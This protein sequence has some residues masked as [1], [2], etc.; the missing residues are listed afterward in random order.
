MKNFIDKINAARI[1][2]DE[3]YKKSQNF[4]IINSIKYQLD[5][6]ADDFDCS[7]NFKFTAAKE[8]VERLILGVQAVREI[9]PIYPEFADLLCEIDYEYKCLYGI[10]CF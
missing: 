2:A 6:I 10:D 5:F 9:E 4:P 3:I 1:I 7:G 8:N